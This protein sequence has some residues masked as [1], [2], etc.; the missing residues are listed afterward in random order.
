MERPRRLRNTPSRKE[1]R[2][3]Q[4]VAD[5]L[6]RPRLKNQTRTQPPLFRESYPIN[7]TTA[8]RESLA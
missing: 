6:M 1:R 8:V 3:V 4:R 5:F 2:A 7:D